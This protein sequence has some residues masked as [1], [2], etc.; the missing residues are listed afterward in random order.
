MRF[1]CL[2]LT[3]KWQ[4]PA[5][6]KQWLRVKPAD[7][8][9]VQAGNKATDWFLGKYSENT[10]QTVVDFK[11]HL[12]C[13]SL[14]TSR[15]T[16]PG[17]LQLFAKFSMSHNKNKIV[18]S[19]TRSFAPAAVNCAGRG[20]A[21]TAGEA[22]L[23]KRLFSRNRCTFCDTVQAEDKVGEVTSAVKFCFCQYRVCLCNRTQRTFDLRDI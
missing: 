20:W 15:R 6:L 22:T 7:F 16:P 19:F 23:K 4:L 14:S 12:Q 18:H 3:F 5:K 11:F 21:I 8:L 1:I 2:F 13:H 17:L 9:T 10:L